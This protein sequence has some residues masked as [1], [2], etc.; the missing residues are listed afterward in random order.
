MSSPSNAPLYLSPYELPLL[1]ESEDDAREVEQLLLD[2]PLLYPRFMH[3]QSL[4]RTIQRLEKTI[5][6]TKKEFLTAYNEMENHDLD[7]AIRFFVAR[8]RHDR[9]SPYQRETAYRPPT[10]P[11]G[12]QRS[13][14]PPSSRPKRVPL[15]RKATPMPKN[16]EL[17]SPPESRYET[18]LENRLGIYCWDCGQQ[19]HTEDNC[20]NRRCTHC[21]GRGHLQSAC[22]QLNDFI[23]LPS[24]ECVSPA[25]TPIRNRDGTIKRR[26]FTR[27]C[28]PQ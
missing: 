15:R 11:S 4:F 23:V 26:P 7:D 10:T 20:N 1:I 12:S 22:Q 13:V 19:G 8:K 5:E 17:S 27:S 25:G 2:H 24:G 3:Y 18:A 9:Y 28:I 16:R 21:N 6:T 14:N